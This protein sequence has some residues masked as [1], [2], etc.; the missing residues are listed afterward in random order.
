MSYRKT[1]T[2]PANVNGVPNPAQIAYALDSVNPLRERPKKIN[3]AKNPIITPKDGNKTVNPVDNFNIVVPNTSQQMAKA[4][5]IK[6]LMTY[7]PPFTTQ[8]LITQSP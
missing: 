1:K 2:P 4:K 6:Y 5:N 8:D 3:E 7:F